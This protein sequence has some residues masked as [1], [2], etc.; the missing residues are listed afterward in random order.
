M[1]TMTNEPSDGCAYR[2]PVWIGV[3]LILVVHFVTSFWPGVALW[4][5]DYW[6]EFPLPVRILMLAAGLFLIVPPVARRLA[7][8]V[9][10]VP[11]PRVAAVVATVGLAGLMIL[12]RTRAVVYGDAY[13][14]LAVIENPV[15]PELIGNLKFRASCQAQVWMTLFPSP[16][17]PTT[18]AGGPSP[19]KR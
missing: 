13:S 8:W 12:F 3:A 11:K 9:V 16:A 6:S 15:I 10:G 5:V 4:G 2:D 7:A 1:A 17:S 18:A 14:I 19:L